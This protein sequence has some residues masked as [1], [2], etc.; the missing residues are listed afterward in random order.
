MLRN[1]G[2][3]VC[4]FLLAAACKGPEARRPVQR[5]SGSFIKE[6]AERNSLLYEAEKERIAS[7]MAQDSTTKYLASDSGFW[8]F[9]NVQDT[10]LG[11]TPQVGDAVT[12]T[13]D[14]KDLAGNT[15]LSKSETGIQNYKIDQTNQELISGLRDGLKLMREGETVTFLFPSYKAFGYYGIENKLGTNVPVQSTVTLDTIIPS[16]EN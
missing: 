5:S 15:I 1:F 4:L 12:F 7:I 10:L 16:E 9:Y 14:I 6:S 13:Y 11:A 8:Y 2:Y 3:I